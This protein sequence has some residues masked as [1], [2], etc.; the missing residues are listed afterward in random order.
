MP[1]ASSSPAEPFADP[2]GLDPDCGA[3][4][5]HSIRHEPCVDLHVR[6]V[7]RELADDHRDPGGTDRLSEPRA[8]APRVGH[9]VGS[10]AEPSGHRLGPR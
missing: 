8:Q 4:G 2:E 3:S 6:V 5:S 10:Q 1:G 9:D 7:V